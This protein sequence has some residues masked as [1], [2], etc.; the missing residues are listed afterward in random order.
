MA[1][2]VSWF[3]ARRTQAM[4]RI[5]CVTKALHMSVAGTN[6]SLVLRLGV[7]QDLCRQL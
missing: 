6:T 7:T 4:S 3:P 5:N 1:R 2:V